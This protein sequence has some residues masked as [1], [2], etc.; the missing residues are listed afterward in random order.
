MIVLALDTTGRAG[1]VALVRDHQVLAEASGDPAITHAARLPGELIDLLAQAGLSL[2]AVDL[3]AVAAGPG[4]FTGLRV[5]IAAMQG[6]AMALGK[7]IVPVS[8][9]EALARVVPA[10]PGEL[11]APW[12]DA[13][14]GEVFASLYETG[15][16]SP[17]LEPTA[18]PP[19]ETVTRIATFAA[20]RRVRFLGDGAARYADRIRLAMA[21][22]AEVAETVPRLAGAIGLIAAA[23]PQRAVAPHAVAPLYV[24][25]PDVELTRERRARPA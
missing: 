8:T 13:Q 18:L 20:G 2:A 1:S 5:G 23:A 4:S 9:L 6:L 24:R 14:R 16:S 7:T 17:V 15:E 21:S 22:E 3:L 10:T 12:V 11:I 25:R 19:E